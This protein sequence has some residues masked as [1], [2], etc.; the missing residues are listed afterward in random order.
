MEAKRVFL[1][2]AWESDEF[3]R[4]VKQLATR[5]REDGVNARLD[6]WNLQKNGNIAE[7]M[8]REVHEADWVVVLCSPGYQQRVRAT[9]NGERIGGVGWEA[10]L[11][12]STLLVRNQNKMLAVLARGNWEDAAPDL[13]MGQVY[14]DLS[15]PESFERHYDDLLRAIAGTT[16]IAPPLGVLPIIADEAIPPL[17][18]VGPAD[19]D[20]EQ[21]QSDFDRHGRFLAYV[22]SRG[23]T[24]VVVIP[25]SRQT[26]T[27]LAIP[28]V[29]ALRSM[30]RQAVE[31]V[32]QA[33]RSWRGRLLALFE[34]YRK[35]SSSVCFTFSA[36]LH[37]D[38]PAVFAA[39][40]IA[41]VMRF[42]CDVTSVLS[43]AVSASDTTWLCLAGISFSGQDLASQK[44]VWSDVTVLETEVA[45]WFLTRSQYDEVPAKARS[46]SNVVLIPVDH[47]TDFIDH[48]FKFFIDRLRNDQYFG[49]I[50]SLFS[51]WIDRI[52]NVQ[53]RLDVVRLRLLPEPLSANSQSPATTS[54][55]PTTGPTTNGSAPD[56]TGRPPSGRWPNRWPAATK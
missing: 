11:L 45:V 10:R 26:P 6:A 23:I 43:T 49:P 52:I 27:V 5:L 33:S 42:L 12:S 8:N 30:S 4:W 54:T 18:H 28:E 13:L 53:D 44:I 51:N 48:A 38:S 41:Y 22:P 7:F 34:D 21:A 40:V 31:F 29:S 36:P 32:E 24:A 25:R 14:F 39:L 56:W 37:S 9:E 46:L 55:T 35:T 3:C 16:E 2:Y 17:R 50:K 19:R 15:Q 1:S 47:P 20:I